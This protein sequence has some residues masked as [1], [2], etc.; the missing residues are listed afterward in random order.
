M[1]TLRNAVIR[2]AGGKESVRDAYEGGADCGVPGFTYYSDTV[3]FWK[4]HKAA[5][6]ALAEEMADSMGED[7]LT[8]VAG[9][10]CIQGSYS[11]SE[12]GKVLYGRDTNDSTYT[13]VANAMT[14]FALEEVA[15]EIFDS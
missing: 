13:Q 15:R 12:V 8:M 2:Q 3:K 4:H 10:G 6:I 14:W 5:I 7:L 9:F 1:A 11:T